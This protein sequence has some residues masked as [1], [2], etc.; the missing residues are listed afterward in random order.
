[1]RG[2]A[3]RQVPMLTLTTPEQRVPKDHPIRRIKQLADAE[4]RA[5]SPVFDRMYS[6]RGRPS[7]PP[8][9]LL[10]GCL[11]IAL[12]SVRSERQFCERLQYDLQPPSAGQAEA[13]CLLLGHAVNHYLGLGAR[14]FVISNPVDQVILNA[15][16]GNRARDLTVVADREE[17]TCWPWGRTPCFHH[18]GKDHAMAGLEPAHRTAKHL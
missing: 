16:S 12:Y 15:T 4:L 8:E 11:L 5:L 14:K 13:G 1:M 2:E 6:D 18:G 17:R 3:E 7:I 9:T 10:K